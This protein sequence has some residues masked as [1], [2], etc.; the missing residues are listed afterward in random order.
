MTAVDA[1]LNICF[2]CL[3]AVGLASWLGLW[4]IPIVLGLQLAL[5][6]G[7]PRE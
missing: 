2:W 7:G 3:V 4:A 5:M 1:I 6:I